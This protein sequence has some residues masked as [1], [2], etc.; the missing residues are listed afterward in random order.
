[1]IVVH[2]N[3]AWC[4]GQGISSECGLIASTNFVPSAKLTLNQVASETYSWYVVGTKSIQNFGL[5][6]VKFM[7]P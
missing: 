5:I 6:S 1:M 4:Q 7:R 2:Y 3:L